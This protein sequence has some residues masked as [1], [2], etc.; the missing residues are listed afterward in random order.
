MGIGNHPFPTA[1]G[2]DSEQLVESQKES[3]FPNTKTCC[4]GKKH[5]KLLLGEGAKPSVLGFINKLKIH[6]EQGTG[7]TL[8]WDLPS[9][10]PGDGCATLHLGP[11]FYL[12]P[13]PLYSK[14][15]SREGPTFPPVP[16]CHPGL[17]ELKPCA[18]TMQG[19]QMRLRC[20][21][22]RSNIHAPV[23]TAS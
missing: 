10:D 17:Q 4:S 5:G 13:A 21:L 1:P 12:C 8:P 11:F 6:Q 3:D 20:L 9:P 16:L 22:I 7:I 14:L 19:E 15:C 18:P 2:Q 23:F